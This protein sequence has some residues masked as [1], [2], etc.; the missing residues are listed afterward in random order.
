[1]HIA[2]IKSY[3]DKPWR[4]PETYERIEKELS[5]RWKLS[6][7]ETKDPSELKLF[8]DGLSQKGKVFVFN[9]AE[10]LDEKSKHS[11]LPGLLDGWGFDHLGSRAEVVKLGLDKA[12]TKRALRQA[13]V[14]TPDDFLASPGDSEASVLAQAE[15]IGF[16]LMVKPSLEGG[17]LGIGDDSIVHDGPALSREVAKIQNEF[18]QPAL[19][20]KYI[21]GEGMREFSVGV[22]E[23]EKPFFTPVEIDYASMGVAVPILSHDTAVKDLEKVVPV[24]DEKLARELNALAWS[25][26]KAVGAS[27]YSRVDIR[28]DASSAF[29]LEINVM[30][31]LGPH[32]F[33]PE[34][35]WSLH[36]LSYG[37]LMATLVETALGRLGRSGSLDSSSGADKYSPDGR[38]L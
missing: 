10:F 4:S 36:G 11:F 29:V 7:I 23:A 38:P 31:G 34:A 16:P 22:I 8:L 14:P 35:A 30:P 17:H 1:M 20:E 21:G 15:L 26:F 6:S 12:G 19:V 18:K 3:T 24:K 9:I 25:C 2:L 32:S 28:S 37:E 13:G 33:L 27:D 5:A